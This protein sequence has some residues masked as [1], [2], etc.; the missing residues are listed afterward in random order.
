MWFTKEYKDFWLQSHRVTDRIFSEESDIQK[1]EVYRSEQ[2]GNIL[3]V[4]EK[5][6]LTQKDDFI[7]HEMLVHVP[8]CTHKDPKRVLV[9]GGGNG[10]CVNELLKHEGV[11][12]DMVEPDSEVIEVS[13]E[14]FIEYLDALN[15]DSCNVIIETTVDFV[16]KCESKIYD[17]VIVDAMA[18]VRTKEGEIFEESFFTEIYRILKDDGVCAAQAGSWWLEVDQ[19]R[20]V[21]K[22]MGKLFNIVL[23]YRYEMY[24]YPGC[25]FTSAIAS[26][27]YHPTADIILQRADLLDDLKYYNSD[28][29]KAAFALPNYIE[30]SLKEVLK[31]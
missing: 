5:L 11:T 8:M 28:V 1:I 4:D 3:A 23:P 17:V 31:K 16:K 29:H 26:K 27:K 21:L 12:I 2:F 15:S 18:P 10:G 20:R 22:N 9:L 30:K 7:H 14:F 25:V 13:K 6:V 19:N 24:L